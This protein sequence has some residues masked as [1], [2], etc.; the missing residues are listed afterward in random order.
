[1]TPHPIAIG[2]SLFFVMNVFGN[3]AVFIGLVGTYTPLRQRLILIREFG[4]AL[5]ILLFFNYFGQ[6][7]FN[8]LGITQS[9]LGI[10]GGILLLLI[11][12][13]MIFPRPH[14]ESHKIQHEPFLVPIATPILAG[15]GSIA[16]VMIFS[17]HL[18]NQLEMS[19][20]IFIVVI[21]S[22]IISLGISLCDRLKKKGMIAFERLGGML[23]SLIAVEMFAQGV[24][25]L[26]KNNFNT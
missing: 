3:I 20:I 8:F 1:M 12:I 15:P 16:A 4:F 5:I 9:I 11:A 22:C 23:I 19:L 14:R 18:H 24:V 13:M 26:V 25:A 2:L 6:H 17:G 10:A 21:I 7:I